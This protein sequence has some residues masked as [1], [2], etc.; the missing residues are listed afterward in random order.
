MLYCAALFLY[1]SSGFSLRH[2]GVALCV[3][4]HATSYRSV[5]PGVSDGAKT[6]VGK[7][8]CNDDLCGL[9]SA[10]HLIAMV[11]S[12]TDNTGEYIDIFACIS[13]SP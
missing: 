8:L 4:C 1:T 10:A 12:Q 9:K 5:P 3:V 13:L 6:G 2:K 11:W 7:V